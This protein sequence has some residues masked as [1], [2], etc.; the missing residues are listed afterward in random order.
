MQERAKAERAAAAAVKE[1][2][3]AAAAAKE[4][5]RVMCVRV[6]PTDTRCKCLEEHLL[7]RVRARLCP[8]ARAARE[9]ARQDKLASRSAC[10]CHCATALVMKVQA[11]LGLGS[12]AVWGMLNP[13]STA[14]A[15]KC[16]SACCL[17]YARHGVD[18]AQR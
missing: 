5:V 2:E 15:K 1:L 16:I 6:Q 8:Q 9:K 4:E 3:L 17:A 10:R 11:K 14:L 18:V 12:K 13:T 7:A